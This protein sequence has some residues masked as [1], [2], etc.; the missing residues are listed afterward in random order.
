M[1]L[2]K[3]VYFCYCKASN[4]HR[5]EKNQHWFVLQKTNLSLLIEFKHEQIESY[6]VTTET[7]TTDQIKRKVI[8]IRNCYSIQMCLTDTSVDRPMHNT[9]DNDEA[10]IDWEWFSDLYLSVTYVTSIHHQSPTDLTSFW[11]T[12]FHC[13]TP[14]NN[15][16]AWTDAQ[17]QLETNIWVYKT[18]R[19]EK[20]VELNWI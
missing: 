11:F 6:L 18:C 16:D 9:H 7:N 15:G 1:R 3:A 13:A 14:G 19:R 17:Q 10:R 4:W 5:K 2:L 12:C 20:I 8:Q